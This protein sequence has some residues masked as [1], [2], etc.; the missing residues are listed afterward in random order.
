MERSPELGKLA[1]QFHSLL[2]RAPSWDAFVRKVRGR[3]CLAP[4][5]EALSHPAAVE[6]L[7]PLRDDGAP[8]E[9]TTTEWSQDRL[10]D[11]IDR[12]SHASAHDYLGFTEREMVDFIHKGYWIVLPADVA[13]YIPQ[14]RLSPLGVVP[15]RDRRPRI[16]VDYTFSGV[17]PETRKLA[18]REAMQ[19]GRALDRIL[20]A[21]LR[22][23]PE[24]GPV[25]LIKVDLSDGFYRIN[26]KPADAPKLGLIF[27]TLP[28]ERPL[29]AIPLVLPM[30][31]TESPPWFCAATETI[32]DLANDYLGTSWDPPAH[33][34]E[35]LA[36]S[37]PDTD[38]PARLVIQEPPWA[39]S[40]RQARVR[41]LP[42][43]R[44]RRRDRSNRPLTY[45]DVFVDDEIVAAQGPPARLRRLRR[46]LFHINDQVMR[47][48]D[49]ADSPLRKNPI[50]DSKLAKGDALW[51][52]LKV[53]LGWLVDTVK[54]TIELPP[55]RQ[56]R[57]RDL[58]LKF[59]NLRRISTTQAH[60]LLGELRS[61]A[62]GLPGSAGMLSLLQN[63]L[64]TALRHKRRVL[65]NRPTRDHLRDLL[66]LARNVGDRPTHIAELFPQHPA[67]VAGCCDA[68]KLGFGGVIFPAPDLQIP[69]IVW[70]TP[71]PADLQARL[72]SDD[73]PNGTVT[74]SD[75]EL[76][77]T[78][79]HEAILTRYPLR[80]CTILTGS[81][82]KAAI[83][84]R[85]KGSNSLAG[86]S[87][88]L[89]RE[90]ALL[91]RRYRY[92][93]RLTFVNGPSNT[94][95]DTASRRFDLTDSQL[96]ALLDQSHP[97]TQPWRMHPIPPDAHSRVIT[98]LHGRRPE[99]PLDMTVQEL[100]TA[101]GTSAGSRTWLTS[102]SPTRC[103][104][105]SVTKSR[106]YGS[107]PP[108]SAPGACPEVVSAS[109]LHTYGTRSFTSQR[110]SS[111]WGPRTHASPSAVTSIPVSP[112]ST[113]DTTMKTR[114]RGGSSPY[115][116]PFCT[117]PSATTT[118][119][120]RSTR[121]Y[122]TWPTL[123]CST[124]SV[125]ESTAKQPPMRRSYY[126]TSPY[127]LAQGNS[128]LSHAPCS[129]FAAP[130]PPPSPLTIKKIASVE[131]S[132]PMPLVG[133]ALRAQPKRL[134]GGRCTSGNTLHRPT[135]PSAR[136]SNPSEP[137][138][139]LLASL[140]PSAP[141]QPLSRSSASARPT[142]PRALCALAVP[143]PCSAEMST[144][145][146]LNSWAA[147]VP[148]PCSGIFT[149]KPSP[150][151]AT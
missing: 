115:R 48:N 137:T 44:R 132:S 55:H 40:Q 86:P 129:T 49:D 30:G 5:L 131:K 37:Q 90:V 8:V 96:L 56:A 146:R 11:A 130:P 64:T 126:A 31:W 34:Q 43:R 74:N 33:P 91:Q 75:L 121:H 102:E 105:A 6:L 113:K 69:P 20:L 142:S 68:S 46:Q 3:S 97:Q 85:H 72:I 51:S 122:S 61:M 128:T 82:N 47:P 63:A 35:A 123:P 9:F 135:P 100:P 57:L 14:T 54:K 117:T 58:L 4:S 145:T 2:Q 147:G 149:P 103:S 140:P 13:R 87:A 77:G 141:P 107:S 84:W 7:V 119:A 139:L 112:P 89:L 71:V 138:S 59:S 1:N 109:V 94:A 148:M 116:S 108:G 67:H 66:S 70:R 38:F 45:V 106:Y 93:S 60:R 134:P 101:S 42:R 118:E 19:F 23:P 62:L 150:L 29:A 124:S 21:V 88:Y 98:A 111:N 12:G 28:D 10:Q 15:Q 120:S 24:H 25:Y 110:H 127:K 17:N 114:H 133:T 39:P 92:T 76:A 32:V 73:N 144:Q 53:V 22:A 95:A 36:T 78:V 65:L 104:P 41:A 50:S 16:I 80:E 18:P 83:A 125:P 27:P 99:T 136:S 81:D 151:F 26:L 79:L 143:W 52:T